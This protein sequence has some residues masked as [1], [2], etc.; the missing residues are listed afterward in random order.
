MTERCKKVGCNRLA[1]ANR[2]FC[3]IEHSP[4]GK[5]KDTSDEKDRSQLTSVGLTKEAYKTRI[6]PN[7]KAVKKRKDQ[8]STL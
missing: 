5:L 6:Q 4:W 2:K 8:G 7:V 3:C 1:Q